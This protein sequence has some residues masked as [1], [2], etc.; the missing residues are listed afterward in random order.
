MPK[1]SEHDEL[2]LDR[3]TAVAVDEAVKASRRRSEVADLN[4][5]VIHV[6]NLATALQV[7]PDATIKNECLRVAALALRLFEEE[8]DI[9]ANDA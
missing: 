4:R 7:G 9:P 3:V 5:L 1:E 8:R 6:G 2:R